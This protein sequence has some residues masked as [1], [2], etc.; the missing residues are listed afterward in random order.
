MLMKSVFSV[1]LVSLLLAALTGHSQSVTAIK[2]DRLKQ[3]VSQPGDTLY[4]VN[5]WAT[6]CGPCIKE[7]PAFEATR[8]ANTDRKVKVLL[9]SMDDKADLKT[10]VIP[11]VRNRK[12]RS[13]VILLDE[14]DP[15]TW[16]DK[17][18]PEWSGALPMT[19]VIN[20]Q[21]NIR[22]F[23]NKPIK[24]EELASIINQYKR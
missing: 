19:L 22:R 10:K 1:I 6:W 20:N 9:V 11:F 18:A 15:N 4:V 2:F 7:M 5:F 8:Q 13:Q 21:R 24:A 14:P 16:I 12:I 23:I 17:L 3:M